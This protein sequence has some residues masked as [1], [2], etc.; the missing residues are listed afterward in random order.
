MISFLK[1]KLHLSQIEDPV[2]DE[3]GS[4]IDEDDLNSGEESDLERSLLIKRQQPRRLFIGRQLS[5]DDGS[6]SNEY[7]SN[8][9]K[10]NARRHLFLGKRANRYGKRSGIHRAFLG[11]RG[12]LKRIFI[13]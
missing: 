10:K 8:V 4:L 3:L 13:G 1:D 6:D 11:K 12:D 2:S 9:D 5:N 7:F